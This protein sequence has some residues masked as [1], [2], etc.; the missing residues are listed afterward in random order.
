M[1]HAVHRLPE[2]DEYFDKALALSPA[3]IS[4]TEDR[5]I[6]LISLGD[7]PRAKAVVH[8]TLKTADSTELAAY[9]AL[10]QEMQWVL[11]EP[12]L[13]RIT[14]MTPENFRNNRQQWGLK[15]GATWKLLGDSARGRAYGD[16]ARIVA[17]AQL[18][19]YPEDAQLH[20]LRARSLALMDTRKEE[21]IAEAERALKMRETALDASTGPYVRYQ[22][23]RVF[24]QAGAYDRALDIIE[25][26]LTTNYADISPAWL[27]LEPVFRPLRGNPRFD[28]LV[29]N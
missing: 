21:A 14:T 6:N 2:S 27:R 25:P 24:I 4:Y 15:V 12:L 13:R 20:E 16:S 7:L 22:A 26:L 8:E 3:N 10:F 23:A 17:E 11:E 19:S 29:K 9:F 1:L 28:R 5:V 18:A